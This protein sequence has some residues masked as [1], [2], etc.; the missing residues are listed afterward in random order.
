M[1]GVIVAASGLNAGVVRAVRMRWAIGLAVAN[2][3]VV[4]VLDARVVGEWDGGDDEWRSITPEG[5]AEIRRQYL[6][7]V[8]EA[9]DKMDIALGRNRLP[10]RK[11]GTARGE[12]VGEMHLDFDGSIL[13]R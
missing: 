4:E 2:D 6:I 11:A 5:W 12:C 7:N 9:M 13:S 10:C 8:R 1:P 3:A